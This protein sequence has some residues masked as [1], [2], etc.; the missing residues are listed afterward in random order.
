MSKKAQTSQHAPL[1]S[2][3]RATRAMYDALGAEGMR[4]WAEE[5]KMD[6]EI[7]F[8]FSRIG[9]AKVVLDVA[10]GYGRTAIPLAARGISVC[11]LDISESLIASARE[12]A[13]KHNVSAQFDVGDMCSLRLYGD[14]TFEHVLCLWSSFIH[15]V[16]EA[17]QLKCINEV[18]RVLKPGGG[19]TFVL[20]DPQLNYWK[21]RLAETDGRIVNFEMVEGHS[22]PV[23]I[24]SETSLRALLMS[25]QFES[26]DYAV[27]VDDGKE[28]LVLS[29][30]KADH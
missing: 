10:C 29:M 28:R 27:Q 19:A 18:H 13:A 22:V 12:S 11:G 24:H 7:D 23:F 14:Q 26:F 20:T 8:V 15:V 4:A 1:D 25:S 9:T 2:T 5:Y 6:D 21:Q 16:D 17:E 30:V 3:K